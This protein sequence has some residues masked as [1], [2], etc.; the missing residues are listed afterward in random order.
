MGIRPTL[1]KNTAAAGI[2]PGNSSESPAILKAAYRSPT[3]SK[4]FKQ[5]LTAPRHEGAKS[6]D[7]EAK[8]KYLAELRAS[9]KKLQDEINKYL[10]EKMEEH[11]G[12]EA[13]DDDT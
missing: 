4:D 3:D 13:G 1:S 7:T 6:L 12:E 11:Y 2:M 5:S 8:S 9:S 10:T